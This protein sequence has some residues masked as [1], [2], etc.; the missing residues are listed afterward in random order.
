MEPNLAGGSH[1]IGE[2]GPPA[3]I[4]RRIDGYRVV[5]LDDGFDYWS[6]V[7][8]MLKSGEGAL[9]SGRTR[10]V[11]IVEE[12]GRTFVF[13]RTLFN[14]FKIQ[15]AL[16][17]FFMGDSIM[18]HVLKKTAA[19]IG[20]GCDVAQPLYLAADLGIY[21]STRE[22]ILLAGFVPGHSLD[23]EAAPELFESEIIETLRSLHRYGLALRDP[24]PGNF[25]VPEGDAGRRLVA[26][27]LSFRS[28]FGLMNRAR[29]ISELN[30]I[31]GISMPADGALDT[32]AANWLIRYEKLRQRLL[33]VKRLLRRL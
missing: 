33:V 9:P 18:A 24:N 20:R 3:F 4:T 25:I 10:M 23:K 15:N 11:R 2:A 1:D 19:A 8:R 28:S 6:I 32:F 26:I 29:D 31:M 5:T 27:D 21:Q 7:D 14:K 13:K 30:R 16:K 22:T 12:G 17:Y